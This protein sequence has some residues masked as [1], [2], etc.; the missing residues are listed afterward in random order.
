MEMYVTLTDLTIYNISV[1]V[2]S[3]DTPRVFVLAH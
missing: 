1:F 2:F 3:I